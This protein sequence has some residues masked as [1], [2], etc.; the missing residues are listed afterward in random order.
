MLTAYLLEV[1]VHWSTR[2]QTVKFTSG[3]GNA[4][5]QRTAVEDVRCVDVDVDA[6]T[7]AVDEAS[8]LTVEDV[9]TLW[10]NVSDDHF[11]VDARV[12]AIVTAACKVSNTEKW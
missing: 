2:R 5:R 3:G 12:P 4:V 8:L 6:G 1:V 7:G 10:R 11:D 9:L